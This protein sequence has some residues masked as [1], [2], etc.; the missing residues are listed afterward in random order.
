MTKNSS[1]ILS[2]IS[3]EYPLNFFD[4]ESIS[5]S[6]HNGMWMHIIKYTEQK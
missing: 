2:L 1:S 6:D 4:R 3:C 5:D